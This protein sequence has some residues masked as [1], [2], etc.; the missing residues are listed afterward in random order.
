MGNDGG[1]IA[2]R[3]ELV[4]VKV[5][6]PVQEA[7]RQ[8]RARWSTCALSKK[9]LKQPVVADGL[10]RM[11]NKEALVN[12]LIQSKVN[13]AKGVKDEAGANMSHVRKLK[14]VT[15]LKLH[16]N[17]AA[18]IPKNGQNGSNG[19]QNSDDEQLPAPFA[20][21]LTG[22]P[23]NG[24]HRF[25]FI[26][27]AGSGAVMSESGLK[28]VLGSSSSSSSSNASA[29]ATCPITSATFEP[30]YIALKAPAS[31][32]SSS[33][34]VAPLTASNVADVIPLNPVPEEEVILRAVLQ[35]STATGKK[36]KKN[37]KR[38]NG[39]EA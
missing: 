32:S 10:G 29:K 33:S 34:A 7:A 15:E 16:D 30:G 28:A 31:S 22:R 11:Y 4:K 9:P 27:A 38:K 1:S 2:R 18:N 36:E 25:V 23:M 14:D 6:K 37:G 24:S 39:D 5:G 20:C 12:W 35:A 8:R 26:R 21:P 3:D 13:D 17:P 19:H